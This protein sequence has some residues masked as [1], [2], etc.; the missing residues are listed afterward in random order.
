MSQQE[1]NEGPSSS[2]GA[3]LIKAERIRQ[4]DVEGWTYKHDDSYS[5]GVLLAAGRCYLSINE[6]NIDALRFNCPP[7]WPWDKEWWKPSDNMER[8]YVKGCAL[9][10][11]ELDL[12]KRKNG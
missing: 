12:R 7:E 11:A 1:N 8:N 3:D 5:T 9:I 4:I 2:Y 6:V 10:A